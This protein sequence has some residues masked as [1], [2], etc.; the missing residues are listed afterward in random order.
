MSLDVQDQMTTWMAAPIVNL[1]KVHLAIAVPV[2]PPE[3]VSI[4]DEE[5]RID[6]DNMEQLRP[7]LMEFLDSRYIIWKNQDGALVMTEV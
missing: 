7:Y 2:N 5:F 1:F 3:I 4:E 6:I